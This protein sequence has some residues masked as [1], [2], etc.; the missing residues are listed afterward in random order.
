MP[1]SQF[2]STPQVSYVTPIS[3]RINATHRLTSHPA[4]HRR[5]PRPIHLLLPPRHHFRCLSGCF[6]K[7]LCRVSIANNVEIWRVL[8]HLAQHRSDGLVGDLWKPDK[9][10]NFHVLVHRQKL[11][12]MQS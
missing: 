10:P 9:R 1:L 7:R 8:L 4:H 12:C 3:L 11:I 5:L 2:F 6:Q